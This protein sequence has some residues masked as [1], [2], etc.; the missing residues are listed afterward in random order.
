MLY[1]FRRKVTDKLKCNYLSRIAEL[2]Q[3][4]IVGLL[5]SCGGGDATSDLCKEEFGL[6]HLTSARYEHTATLLSGGKVLIT[7]GYNGAYLDTVEIYD[8]ATGS[9]S[10]PAN[11]LTGVRGYRT[12]TLPNNGWVPITEGHT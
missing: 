3:F 9:F 1:I 6:P 5:M 8:P 4:C 10:L 12:A 11:T 7:G 2:A